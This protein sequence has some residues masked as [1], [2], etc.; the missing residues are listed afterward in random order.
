MQTDAFAQRSFHEPDALALHPRLEFR[1]TP[2]EQPL[3][4]PRY[5]LT[6]AT[7]V[8]SATDYHH[9][10]GAA[11]QQKL[12]CGRM[13]GTYTLDREELRAGSARMFSASAPRTSN[14]HHIVRIRLFPA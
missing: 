1:L 6:S 9:A 5:T 12:D 2:F 3:R 13:H 7:I 10:A 4:C 11:A 14:Q 8:F